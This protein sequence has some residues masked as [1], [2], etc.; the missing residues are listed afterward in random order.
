MRRLLPIPAASALI[1]A[2]LL[3]LPAAAQLPTGI[4][5]VVVVDAGVEPRQALRYHWSEDHR[6]RLDSVV[7]V[8]IV[9]READQ[10]VMIMQLPISLSVR[11]RVTQVAEDGTA[12]VAMTYDDLA[13]GPISASGG[14]LPDG[15][16]EAAAFDAAMA[17]IAPLLDQTRAWQVIDDRGAVLSTRMDLPD[18]FPAE[19]EDQLVQTSASVALLPEEPV[20]VGARW[21][22]TGTTVSQGV[23]LGVTTTIELIAIDGDEVALAM[24]LRLADGMEAELPTANPF[25]QFEIL[26]GGSYLLDLGGVFP[27]DSTVDMTMTMAG[28]VPNEAGRTVPVDMTVSLDL[29]LETHTLE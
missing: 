14:G 11:A 13:F 15:A 24:S 20:G 8:D 29:A 28:D 6:E 27:R 22:S 4:S 5:D 10:P 19:I 23:S 21:E 25:E 18:G 17:A 9:A 16:E 12:T 26:G 3:P 2:L 7:T 1:L